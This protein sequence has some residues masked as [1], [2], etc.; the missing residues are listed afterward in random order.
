MDYDYLIVGAGFGGCVLAERLA[1]GLGQR[2]LLIDRRDHIGGNAYDFVDDA[3]IIVQKY[4]PHIFHTSIEQV[5]EYLSAFTTW[6][7]YVHRVLA[8]VSDKLLPLP[9][10]LETME[11][12][13]GRPF[14][15]EQLREYFEQRRVRLE[16]IENAR[17]VVVSQ[18]G[19]ELYGLFFEN[20][21]RKQWGLEPYELAA[22]V[23]KRLPVR[24][25][26]DTR[27]FTDTYQ[28]LPTEGFMPLFERL[29]DSPRITVQLRT[30]YRS[31]LESPSFKRLIY[32][33][34][35][36]EFFGYVHGRLPYRSMAFEF[37]TLEQEWFQPAGVVNYPNEQD[38]TRITEFKHLYRQKCP[39]TTICYEYSRAEG[40]P[41]YPI[42]TQANRELYA[43]Y[44]ALA[45]TRC[46]VRFVGRLAQYEY[47]NMDQV[48][49]RALRLFAEIE[50]DGF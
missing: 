25:D 45:E 18:V 46:D 15:A 42:P 13:Y 35:I 36:D 24:F 30:D 4:G 37:R 12:L 16:R 23:T 47:L 5:W 21:T 39:K 1:N 44:R 33:G 29:V 17:D 43:K 3:G 10:S 41:C 38:Y 32:T 27:Y 19:R 48:V 28:G 31:M 20:Y 50:T 9:I 34:A 40:P 7:G 26:R 2:V 22:D 14:S 6:N 49:H 8:K 11:Q